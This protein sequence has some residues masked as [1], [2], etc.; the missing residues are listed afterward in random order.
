[1]PGP[2]VIVGTRSSRDARGVLPV[3]TRVRSYEISAI[4]GQAGFGVTY[5]A[6]DTNLDRRVAIKEYLPLS[7]ALRDAAANVVARS[8]ELEEQYVQGRE[9]FLAQA[10]ALRRL[11]RVPAI[12]HVQDCLEANGTAYMVMALA[13]GETLRRHLA[14]DKRLSPAAVERL[15][16]SLLEGLEQVHAAG[17]LHHDITPASI[18]L[19][20]TGN[21]TLIDF[22]GARAAIAGAAAS[23]TSAFTPGYAAPEQYTSARPGP[24]TDIYGLSATLYHAI[25]GEPPPSVFDRVLADT[26]QPLTRLLP[27][28]FNSSLL[29]GVDAGLRLRP[30]ERP[31]SI[32]DWKSTLPPSGAHDEQAAF[33]MRA[34][35]TEDAAAAPLRTKT[36]Q[37]MGLWVGIATAA[38]VAAVTFDVAVKLSDR[39]AEATGAVQRPAAG[40]PSPSAHDASAREGGARNA[41]IVTAALKAAEKRTQAEPTKAK[42]T[43]TVDARPQPEQIE[44]AL[45]LSGHDRARVQAALAALGFEVSAPGPFG[46]ITRAAIAAWQK[47]QRLAPTGFLDQSQLTTLYSQTSPKREAEHATAGPREAEAALHLSEQDRKQVQAAL[48]AL[49]HE[50]PTTGYFG[51][52]TR[53]AIAAW[54]KTQGVPATGLLDETQRAT[55]CAQATTIEQ[56]KLE[57]Q[58]TEAALSEQDRKRVQAALTALGQAVPTTGYF[59]RITRAAVMAWQRTQS[60]PATGYLT[61]AQLTSLRQQAATAGARF[62]QAWRQD[63]FENN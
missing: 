43:P 50:V 13:K 37:A 25:A 62:D 1:M 15:L 3:G 2:G 61:D 21:P 59:G 47:E 14:R 38:V 42:P 53:A 55:L 34:S 11:D 35:P 40:A 24:W 52:I 17:L 63:P 36:R 39:P 19:D 23:T 54:Q 12:V 45:N 30:S 28:G 26:Y 57:G 46:P 22:A 32:A 33:A 49:G 41:H 16:F 48:T 29:I 9:R 4:L 58:R 31:Q 8:T 60:L 27:A 20:S 51:R 7:L 10:R 6:H 56:V 5:L 44:A 18:I